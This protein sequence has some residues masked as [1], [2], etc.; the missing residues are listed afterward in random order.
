MAVSVYPLHTMYI[1][2]Y[3]PGVMCIYNIYNVH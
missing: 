3:K 2:W 1:N